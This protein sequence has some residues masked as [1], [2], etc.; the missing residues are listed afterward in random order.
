MKSG[1][2]RI[3]TQLTEKRVNIIS[4]RAS[5]LKSRMEILL[6]REEYLDTVHSEMNNLILKITKVEKLTKS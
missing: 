1:L 5:K 6:K 3:N 4:A 2:V